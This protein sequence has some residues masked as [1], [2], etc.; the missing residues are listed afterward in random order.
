MHQISEC[1]RYFLCFVLRLYYIAYIVFWIQQHVLRKYL[2]FVQQ[3]VLELNVP[4]NLIETIV[5]VW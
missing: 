1:K 4:E 3:L 5:S 2:M